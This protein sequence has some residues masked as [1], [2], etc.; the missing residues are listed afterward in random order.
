MRG[1]AFLVSVTAAAL[2]SNGARSIPPLPPPTPV[3]CSA[4]GLGG[5]VR[6]ATSVLGKILSE[7]E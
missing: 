5:Q 2:G 3:P 6:E 7:V 1:T 4:P